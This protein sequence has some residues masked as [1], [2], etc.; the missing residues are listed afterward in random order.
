MNSRLK[1]ILDNYHIHIQPFERKENKCS[2]L[3]DYLIFH[4]QALYLVDFYDR[5]I[6]YQKGVKRLLGYEPDEFDFSNLSQFCHPEDL[7]RYTELMKFSLDYAKGTPIEPFDLE[8]SLSYRIRKKDGSYLMIIR[9]STVYETDSNGYMISNLSVIS[10]ITY[11]NKSNMVEWSMS[12][13]NEDIKLSFEKH[14]E[15]KH[16]DYFSKREMDILAKMREG[17]GSKEIAELFGISRHTVDTHRRRMLA[18]TT[19][20]NSVELVEFAR[21]NNILS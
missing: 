9:N 17:L 3:K 21:Q 11:L 12:T 16:K 7:K 13:P 10:D 18:K 8:F 14:F 4:K 19:C 15:E 20:T 1:S 5:N 2:E 6:C